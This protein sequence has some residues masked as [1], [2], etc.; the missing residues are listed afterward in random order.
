[1]TF[2]FFK[3]V[4]KPDVLFFA[5]FDDV[6]NVCESRVRNIPYAQGRRDYPRSPRDAGGLE[7]PGRGLRV[8]GC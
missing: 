8:R 6:L 2:V 1:M 7:A 3:T 4:M 5:G